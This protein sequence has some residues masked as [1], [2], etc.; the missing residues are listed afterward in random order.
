LSQSF[1]VDQAE[2]QEKFN[3]YSNSPLALDYRELLKEGKKFGIIYVPPSSTVLIPI[4]NGT[5][6]TADG[7][8]KNSFVTDQVFLEEALKVSLQ[9]MRK[10]GLSVKK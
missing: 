8:I 9:L 1:H 7:K 4:K 3:S 10:S 6:R 5:I 2:L